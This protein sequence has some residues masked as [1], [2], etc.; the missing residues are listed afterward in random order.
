M[1]IVRGYQ[2]VPE[3]A[4]G[5]VLA[6]GNFDGVHRGH[7]ALLAAAVQE[8]RRERRPA[9]VLMFEPHPRA[10]FQPDKPHF[11]LTSLPLKLKLLERYGLDLA[12]VLAF[13][14]S[15]ASLPAE[16]FIERVLVA[17]LGVRHVVVGYDFHFGKG[18]GGD[19]ETLRKAGER[20]GFGVTVVAQVAEAGE[21]F[22]S[23]GVRAE[24]AL[25]DVAGAAEML[26]HWWRVAGTVVSGARRGAG[27][28]YPTANI[29]LDP[30][31]AL[32]H[33]IYAVR[34]YIGSEAYQGTAYLGTRPTFDEGA[35]VL[36]VFLFDFD[37]DLYGRILEV[38]FIDFIRADRRFPDA[39]A[40]K[41][42]MDQDCAQARQILARA[43]ASPKI[44]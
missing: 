23:S 26:G 1:Q 25:G 24:L 35:P 28:G 32:A 12:V 17:G 14:Q 31:T 41:A 34:V 37:G 21:V 44:S 7:Q 11:R 4:R 43:P 29:V 30:G 42:Q 27:L 9:G 22:S 3:S 33:G 15:L 6:I 19:P 10:F 40:L 18:R 2:S 8:A 16:A 39:E 38:E 36:E 5:A 20:H 13:N